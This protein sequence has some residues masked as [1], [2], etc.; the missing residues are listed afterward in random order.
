MISN[1]TK[2]KHTSDSF[3]EQCIPLYN[4]VFQQLVMQ[5]P[6]I[7]SDKVLKAGI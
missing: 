7:K 1:S 6:N 5:Y 4:A 2:S 3:K